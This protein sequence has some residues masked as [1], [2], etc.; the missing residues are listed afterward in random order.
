MQSR[1]RLFTKPFLSNKNTG[2]KLKFQPLR[3][4]RSLGLRIGCKLHV[5]RYVALF[6]D[7]LLKSPALTRNLAPLANA[8]NLSK[9]P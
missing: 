4:L 2:D 3:I 7:Y 8:Y 5:H 6:N 1:I 9:R